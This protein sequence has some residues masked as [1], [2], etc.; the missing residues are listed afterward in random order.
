M[1]VKSCLHHR[2]VRKTKCRRYY[3][4]KFSNHLPFHRLFITDTGSSTLTP[5][6]ISNVALSLVPNPLKRQLLLY[7]TCNEIERG[8]NV[9]ITKAVFLCHTETPENIR[10]VLSNSIVWKCFPW[11]GNILEMLWKLTLEI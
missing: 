11:Y 9:T 10:K 8:N 2:R 5:E 6:V 1:R 7:H 3:S 4:L